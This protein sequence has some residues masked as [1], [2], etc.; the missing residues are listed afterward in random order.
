MNDMPKN[1]LI[2]I[3]DRENNELFTLDLNGKITWCND[4]P[5]G[6]NKFRDI[7]VYLFDIVYRQQAR[8]YEVEQEILALLKEKDDE[9]KLIRL[10][11]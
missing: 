8:L 7:L 2:K 4:R 6:E 9:R 1:L 3:T 11:H 10:P 5:C